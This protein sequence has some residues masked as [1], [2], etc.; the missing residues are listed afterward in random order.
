MINESINKKCEQMVKYFVC[1]VDFDL[2]TLRIYY[3]WLLF[4]PFS[5]G[6]M[7]LR[8]NSKIT[9][10]EKRN[11]NKKASLITISMAIGIS[12]ASIK[13]VIGNCTRFRVA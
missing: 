10:K 13:T 12:T 1:C 11:E 7:I 3:R 5:S 9:K 8:F 4:P 2:Q 6:L